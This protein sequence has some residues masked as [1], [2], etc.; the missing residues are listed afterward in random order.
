MELIGNSPEETAYHEAGHIVT[1]AAV[2]LDL[3]PA[4]ILIFEVKNVAAGIAC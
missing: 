3:R 4:G 2:G 1:A